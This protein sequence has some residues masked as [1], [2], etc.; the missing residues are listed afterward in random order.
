VEKKPISKNPN[1]DNS[2][3]GIF[4]FKNGSILLNCIE[5]MFKK[6][7]TVNGEYYIA[8]AMNKL[9]E[10]KKIVKVFLVDQFISWSLPEHLLDYLYWERIINDKN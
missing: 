3:T 7:I 9:I 8:T 6:K 5:N 2:V 10:D 4:Y 1:N